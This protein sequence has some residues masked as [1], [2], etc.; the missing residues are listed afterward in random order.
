MIKQAYL[1]KWNTKDGYI[2]L[3]PDHTFSYAGDKAEQARKSIE[4]HIEK[5]GIREAEK[6]RVKAE[7]FNGVFGQAQ[8]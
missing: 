7:F 4:K 6:T 3:S 8:K 2:A 1:M 5:Y